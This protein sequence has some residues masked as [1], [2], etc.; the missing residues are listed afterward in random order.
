MIEA[1]C[2]LDS[3]HGARRVVVRELW[4]SIEGHPG[5]AAKRFRSPALML[6]PEWVGDLVDTIHN[7]DDDAE[8]IAEVPE[9]DDSLLRCHRGSSWASPG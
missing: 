8:P 6:T 3:H 5:R 7:L 9:L 2:E 4:K 1:E